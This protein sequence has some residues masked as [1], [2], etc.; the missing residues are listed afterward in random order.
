MTKEL[1]VSFLFFP[2][3]SWSLYF[4]DSLFPPMF[5]FSLFVSSSIIFSFYA[6]ILTPCLSPTLTLLH[7]GDDGGEVV[8]Q[9]DHISR[10][11]GHIRT[12][13]PHGNADVGF[14]Q[15]RRVVYAIACHSH[16]RPLY[17]QRPANKKCQ[18]EK[19]KYRDLKP[20]SPL[21]PFCLNN[22]FSKQLWGD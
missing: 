18:E 21:R 1:S 13:D 10:L 11:L 22:V 3:N 5:Y 6:S 16:D 4:T 19:D 17:P 9:Q 15:C 8:V 7:S 14:L 2:S 12:G 20:F